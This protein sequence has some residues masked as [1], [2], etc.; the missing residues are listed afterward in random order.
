MWHGRCSV[1]AIARSRHKLARNGAVAVSTRSIQISALLLFMTACDDD[2]GTENSVDRMIDAS[3]DGGTCVRSWS[4]ACTFDNL[5]AH[6]ISL[7]ACGRKTDSRNWWE[8]RD[9]HWQ[10]TGPIDCFHA[11]P[12]AGQSDAALDA[13]N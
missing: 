9:G 10:P 11:P 6:T 5:C 7:E 4:A 2:S 3:I 12:D 1:L 8:C 13:S